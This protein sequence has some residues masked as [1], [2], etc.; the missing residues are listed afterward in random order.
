MILGDIFLL[1]VLNLVMMAVLFVV[2]IQ[3]FQKIKD[4]PKRRLGNGQEFRRILSLSDFD[5]D[6]AEI[7][8][9]VR[10]E[11]YDLAVQRLMAQT[12][13]D[14]FAAQ[15]AIDRLKQEAYRPYYETSTR[16][17]DEST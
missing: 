8:Q 2:G 5:L 15:S 1:I 6:E 17:S 12:D 3:Q 7:R 14:R 9:L 10:D 13:M 4:K 16:A 11:A